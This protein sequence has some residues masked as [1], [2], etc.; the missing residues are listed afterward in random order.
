VPQSPQ[1]GAVIRQFVRERNSS[2]PGSFGCDLVLIKT[3]N[4]VLRSSPHKLAPNNPLANAHPS[5]QTHA[6]LH[7]YLYSCSRS[8]LLCTR[9]SQTMVCTHMLFARDLCEERAPCL[10][11]CCEV[12]VT[13]HV[14]RALLFVPLLQSPQIGAVNRQLVR[15]RDPLDPCSVGCDPRPTPL[16]PHILAPNNPLAN[17]PNPCIQ[18]RVCRLC[19]LYSCNRSRLLYTRGSHTAVSLP[20]LFAHDPSNSMRTCMSV[21]PA[22]QCVSLIM[23]SCAQHICTRATKPPT[24]SR[25]RGAI[26]PTPGSV[27]CAQDRQLRAPLLLNAQFNAHARSPLVLQVDEGR[28]SWRR[29]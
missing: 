28:R 24:W 14:T 27:G 6:C 21:S 29:R 19:C 20:M 13:R 16:H 1:S 9:G 15:E 5:I 26:L 3:G 8:C 22:T 12:R 4:F 25:V 7:L 2:D 23:F 17:A 10:Y 18:M 11:P